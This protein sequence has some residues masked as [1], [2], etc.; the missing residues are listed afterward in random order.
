METKNNTQGYIDVDY[1]DDER[2]IKEFNAMLAYRQ[3][4][5]GTYTVNDV[6][7][8]NKMFVT[9]H[10][11]LKIDGIHNKY[12]MALNGEVVFEVNSQGLRKRIVYMGKFRKDA[13]GNI[14][15]TEVTGVA[16]CCVILTKKKLDEWCAK[17][18]MH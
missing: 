5:T 1:G 17:I 12:F 4:K 14:M 11:V 16:N 15:T 8:P 13:K 7:V 3:Q 9:K 2:F 18:I 10:N 6:K